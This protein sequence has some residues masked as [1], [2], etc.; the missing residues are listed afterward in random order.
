MA[1]FYTEKIGLRYYGR[2]KAYGNLKYGPVMTRDAALSGIRR[3]VKALQKSSQ[4][5]TPVTSSRPKT[6]H[7]ALIIDRSGSMRPLLGAAIKALNANIQAIKENAVKTGQLTFVSVYAFSGGTYKVRGAQNVRF[8]NPIGD[9]EVI[10]TGQTSLFDAVG[11]AINDLMDVHVNPGDDVSYVVQAITDG[12]ENNS[13][14]FGS[15]ALTELMSYVQKTDLWTLTFLVPQGGAGV[16]VLTGMGIPVG[17]I[18]EWETSQRGVETYTV[19]NNNSFGNYFSARS[20]GQ[21]SLK[22]FYTDLSNL[23][24]ADVKNALQDISRNVRVLQVTKEENI[25]DFVEKQLGSYTPGTAFYQ[26]MKDEKKVQAYKELLV[27]EKNKRAVFGGPD[28]RQ[29]LGIPAGQALKIKPGNHG[30]FD[31][32]VQSTSLNRKLPRGTK[33]LVKV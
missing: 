28:A 19:A 1:N 14:V 12:E 26:L 2:S 20:T 13:R 17:N 27:M 5:A 32:F 9:H 21:T 24:P 4:P 22:S 25:K 18:A 7:I 33:L 31:I 23:K 6:N 10:A 16:R 11:L 30:N 29:V 15:R 8:I 3:K